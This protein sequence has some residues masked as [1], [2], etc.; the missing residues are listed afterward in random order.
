MR[1]DVDDDG[2]DDADHVDDDGDN[3]CNLFVN[4]VDDGVLMILMMM[5]TMLR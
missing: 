4:H 5:M 1:D 3:A 2:N